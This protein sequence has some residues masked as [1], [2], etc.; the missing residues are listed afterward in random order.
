MEKSS[1]MESKTSRKNADGQEH[2]PVTKNQNYLFCEFPIYGLRKEAGKV[3]P[4]FCQPLNW[5]K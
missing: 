4:P 5:D 2:I 3:P 1:Y